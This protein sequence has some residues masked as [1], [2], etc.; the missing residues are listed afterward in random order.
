M[1]VFVAKRALLIELQRIAF[2]PFF[3]YH[4]DGAYPVV[5]GT[6]TIFSHRGD[7]A[8]VMFVEKLPSLL[9]LFVNGPHSGVS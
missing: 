9:L 4:G 1:Y 3:S 6:V 2:C 8:Y 5:C 7:R